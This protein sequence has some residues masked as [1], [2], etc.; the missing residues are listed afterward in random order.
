M[1]IFTAPIKT[2]LYLWKLSSYLASHSPF[3]LSISISI[4]TTEVTLKIRHMKKIKIRKNYQMLFRSDLVSKQLFATFVKGVFFI[5]RWRKFICNS[6]RVRGLQ[7]EDGPMVT[8]CTHGNA[9]VKGRR[10]VTGQT[11]LR[12]WRVRSKFFLWLDQEWFFI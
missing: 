7:P 6:Q 4:Y 10:D 1:C 12:N 3:F 9:E 11:C 8:L 5:C 2:L